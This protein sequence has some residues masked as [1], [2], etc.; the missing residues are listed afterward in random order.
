MAQSVRPKSFLPNRLCP[1]SQWRMGRRRRIVWR[2]KGS[3]SAGVLVVVV[4]GLSAWLGSPQADA[5]AMG[6][7]PAVASS[8][9]SLATQSWPSTE[10]LRSS[11]FLS[12]G[13][14]R[15]TAT[16]D[17][18]V[19]AAEEMSV[20]FV[21]RNVSKHRVK[22]VGFDR[23]A[24]YPSLVLKAPD[25]TTY[26]APV[27]WGDVL[28][29][30]RPRTL[31][32]GAVLTAAV[33]VVV[34][35]DGPLSVVPECEGKPLPTLL[36]Q[37]LAPGPPSDQSTAIAE[38]VAAAGHLLD[39]C[40]PQT[41]G[42]PVEGQINPPSGNA[43]PLSAQ[44]SIS[45]SS[46][47]SFWVA[48]VLVLTPPGLSGLSIGTAY[49]TLSYPPPL[50]TPPP[51]EAIAWEFVVTKDVATPVISASESA[52]TAS[53]GVIEWGWTPT[54]WQSAGPGGC[55]GYPGGGYSFGLTPGPFIQF[56]LTCPTPA[57]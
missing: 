18:P 21:L 48:Q 16:V 38:V 7:D 46:E 19:E 29:H 56:F 27:H 36:V 4:L 24:G 26:N 23:F 53:N 25:G 34:R 49:E 5:A 10:T 17:S 50:S 15:C 51:W 42:V 22:G 55:V 11:R 40:R 3:V 47:G 2:M 28:S 57:P 45:F 14:L 6:S 35:W 54:G 13:R 52:T 8:A 31:R 41:P 44:C 20:T 43:P 37:V 12:D 39:Q 9:P 1:K 33:S 32:R 30:L